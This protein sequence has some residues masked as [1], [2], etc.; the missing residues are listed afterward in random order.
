MTDNGLQDRQLFINYEQAA[1][2]ATNAHE[3]GKWNS[4]KILRTLDHDKY[5]V[6]CE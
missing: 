3:S 2:F 5:M 4:V 6:V 1:A